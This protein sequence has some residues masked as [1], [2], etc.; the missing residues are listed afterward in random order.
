MSHAP[1]AKSLALAALCGLLTAC[2]EEVT[3]PAQPDAEEL[4]NGESRRIELRY[5]RLDAE[6]FVQVLDL[7]AIKARFPE[8]ILRETWL[9]DMDLRPLITNAL[10]TLI[11]TDE[12]D[13]PQLATSAQNMWELLNMTPISTLLEGTS[14]A[15]LVGVGEAVGINAGTI[16]ADLLA[17]DPNAS[18]ITVDMTT[19]AVIE[20]V[21]GTHPRAKLRLGPVDADHPDGLYPVTPGSL[22]VS[23]WDVV[24]DFAEMPITFGPAKPDPSDPNAPVHPGFIAGDFKFKA[25]TPDFKMTVKVDLNALPYKGVDLTDGTLANVNSTKSQIESAFDFT[26][27]DW[28]QIEGL[29]PA[30]VVE[31][32]TMR[33]YENPDF[34]ASGTSRTPPLGDSPV[35]Q[36]PQW[37][38]ERLLAELAVVRAADIAPHCTVYTL[39]GKV[40]PPYSAV[41]TCVG[42]GDWLDG[43]TGDPCTPAPG[44]ELCAFDPD[45]LVPAS[46]TSIDI[47]EVFVLDEPPPPPSYFWDI[48]LE[49]AQVRL[50]DGGLAEG[51]GDISFTLK[52]VPVGTTVADLTAQ[53]KA[54]IQKNPAALAAIAEL[55]N[56]NTEGAAD[57]FYYVPGPE[58]PASLQGDYLYFVTPADIE[59]DTYGNPVRPYAYAHPGFYADASLTTKLSAPTP[60]DDDTTHEKLKVAAGDILFMEDDAGRLYRIEVGDKPS[61]HTVALDVKRVR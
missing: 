16:L 53:I 15:A 47:D 22:P 51:Q 23:L 35:W 50:H 52:Q 26:T 3:L 11:A 46:W 8:K 34:V 10:K 4:G 24:T 42:Q 39:P 59:N 17:L 41:Q 40:D 45:A 56:E 28:M 49:V 13:V 61:P 21:V 32:M 33:I 55:L 29:V 12:A 30:L 18:I 37:Q 14:L 7:E 43:K 2:V 57:F 20:H 48:L 58:T 54:N 25:T 60:I 36:L 27:D 5:L 1:A 44:D 9:L 38:F 19:D 31:E 6:D